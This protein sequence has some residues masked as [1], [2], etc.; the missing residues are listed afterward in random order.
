LKR[1]ELVL[2][3]KS[4][5]V[6]AAQRRK[7]LILY[8]IFEWLNN[9]DAKKYITIVILTRNITFIDKLEKRTRSRMNL[10]I[11]YLH[12]IRPAEIVDVIRRRIDYRIENTTKKNGHLLEKIRAAFDGNKE[13]MKTLEEQ[14]EYS[15]RDITHYLKIMKLIITLDIQSVKTLETASQAQINAMVAEGF[16]RHSEFSAQYKIMAKNLFVSTLLAR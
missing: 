13:L 10:P 1:K 2:V 12:K 15:P 9:T 16:S 6:L 5:E 8:N 3:I 4:A 14:Y 7:Q 11:V